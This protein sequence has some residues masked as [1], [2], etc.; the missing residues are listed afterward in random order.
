VYVG[1]ARPR[2]WLGVGALATACFLDDSDETEVEIDRATGLGTS[3]Y[4]VIGK[5]DGTVVT[6][7]P[8]RP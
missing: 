8:G 1:R 2:F 5:A 3:V 4:T 6:M 7:F